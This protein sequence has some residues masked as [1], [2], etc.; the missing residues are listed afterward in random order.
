MEICNLT[1]F[2]IL[3][4]LILPLLIAVSGLIAIVI[5]V[6]V[7]IKSKWIAILVQS[8]LQA[9]IAKERKS[10]NDSEKIPANVTPLQETS[11]DKGELVISSMKQ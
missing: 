9:S 2:Y 3:E 10:L 11:T 4:E 5:A 8:I 1:S 7:S 6:T